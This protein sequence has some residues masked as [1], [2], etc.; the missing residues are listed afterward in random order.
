MF[1]KDLIVLSEDLLQ[2]RNFL[3][4]ISNIFNEICEVEKIG[5]SFIC[6]PDS[7]VLV[8]IF[9]DSSES[10]NLIV[11]IR[12]ESTSSIKIFEIIKKINNKLKEMGLHVTLSN[13]FKLHK[14]FN[15]F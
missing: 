1:V 15:F 14:F 6:A 9:I 11:K 7:E 10:K 4:Q 8:T 3:S 5:A 13:D 2:I 12:I